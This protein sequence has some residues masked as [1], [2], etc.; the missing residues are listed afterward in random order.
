[1][2]VSLL[3]HKGREVVLLDFSGITDPEIGLAAVDEAQ[4]F[5]SRR[6]ADGTTLTC[7]DITDTRYD[8]RVVDAFKAMTKAN[9]AIVRAA[10]VVNQSAIHRA[11]IAVVALF[12]R[13]KIEVFDTREK[14]LD[15][16]VTQK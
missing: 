3:Q 2:T 15:W 6:A 5:M 8:R 11:A 16:L 14:A 10:A 1:M 7:T 4:A 13:R 9:R 12:S